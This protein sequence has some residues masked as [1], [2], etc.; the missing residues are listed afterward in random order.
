MSDTKIKVEPSTVNEPGLMLTISKQTAMIGEVISVTTNLPKDWTS[1]SL[2]K[3]INDITKAIDQRL[4]AVN[5][6][7][8][9]RTGKRLEELLAATPTEGEA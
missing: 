8:L 7:V 3:A 4:T 2:S 6:K 5:E 1:E 9:E